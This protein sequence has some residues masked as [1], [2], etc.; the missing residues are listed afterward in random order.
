[1][2]GKK[3]SCMLVYQNMRGGESTMSQGRTTERQKDAVPA[4][5]LPR[6]HKL[7]VQIT[8]LVLSERER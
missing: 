2:G 8:G 5:H 7:T 4:K 3:E 6:T 1:M